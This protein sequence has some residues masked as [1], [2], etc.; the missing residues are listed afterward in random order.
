MQ[1]TV[2]SLHLK[3]GGNGARELEVALHE[4]VQAS[5]LELLLSGGAILLKHFVFL[6]VWEEVL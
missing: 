3:G 2:S 1:L 5:L 6:A 4:V